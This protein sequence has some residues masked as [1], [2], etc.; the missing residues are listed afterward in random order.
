MCLA[1]QNV[2]LS[3]ALLESGFKDVAIEKMNVTFTFDSPEEYTRFHQAIA[4]PVHAMLA[5]EAQERKEEIWKA[6]TKTVSKY[7][8]NTGSVKLDNEVICIS[9]TK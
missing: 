1:D 2:L 8:D 7:A 3:N 9:G 4:A 5:N 6:V